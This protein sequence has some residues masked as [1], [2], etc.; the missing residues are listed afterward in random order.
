MN[1]GNQAFSEEN[2]EKPKEMNLL[3]LFS[4]ILIFTGYKLSLS[5]L[6]YSMGVIVVFFFMKSKL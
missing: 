5:F 3:F 1:E 6:G 4:V 2:I